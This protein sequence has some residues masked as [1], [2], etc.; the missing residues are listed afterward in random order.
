MISFDLST[1]AS[2]SYA[3]YNQLIREAQPVFI[4]ETH[5]PHQAAPSQNLQVCWKE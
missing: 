5:N 1:I 4:P 2:N 3:E